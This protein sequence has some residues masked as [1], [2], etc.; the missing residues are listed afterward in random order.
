M[1]IGLLC[2]IAFGFAIPE[3]L[4]HVWWIRRALTVGWILHLWILVIMTFHYSDI[5]PTDIPIIYIYTYA[6]YIYTK[7]YIPMFFWLNGFNISW[8][9]IL[10]C[11]GPG[12]VAT[13]WSKLRTSSRDILLQCRPSPGASESAP[14]RPTMG[15]SMGD[16]P[17]L[18]GKKCEKN[19]N[20][21]MTWMRTGGT[22]RNLRNHMV[23]NCTYLYI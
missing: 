2:W 21:N 10:W 23:N 8:P 20:L 1:D 19:D 13:C 15:G 22:P 6:Y 7:F 11:M 16:P 3:I 17:F 5:Y 4:K 9:S 18:D 14:D 12:H